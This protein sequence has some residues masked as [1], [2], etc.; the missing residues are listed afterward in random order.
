MLQ[1]V[2]GCRTK[3]HA[4]AEAWD[5]RDADADVRAGA[6]LTRA[7]SACTGVPASR[8]R[9]MPRVWRSSGPG[10]LTEQ[11]GAR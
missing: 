6:P 8:T 10:Q 5:H 9:R 2:K 4:V 3:R 7:P 1:P 11:G